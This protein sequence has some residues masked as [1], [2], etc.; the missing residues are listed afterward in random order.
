MF[1]ADPRPTKNVMRD[2]MIVAGIRVTTKTKHTQ[3]CCTLK[4]NV[5]TS[6]VNRKKD[7]SLQQGDH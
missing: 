4:C 7:N 3:H 2:I 6:K 1:I 5:H